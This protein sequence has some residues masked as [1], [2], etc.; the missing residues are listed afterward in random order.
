MSFLSYTIEGSVADGVIISANMSNAYERCYV[1]VLFY[2]D[3]FETVVIPSTG[4]LTFEAS[5]TGD[6][7]GT[8]TNGTVDVTTEFYDRPNFAG[9]VTRVRATA[10]SITGAVNYRATFS[11]FT[12][13]R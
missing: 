2:S 8:I 13:G 7:F 1:S 6:K 4:T 3:E 11:R 12:S 9:S 5:E 10:A